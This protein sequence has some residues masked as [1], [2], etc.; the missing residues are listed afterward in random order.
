MRVRTAVLVPLMT[1]AISASDQP[2]VG[3]TGIFDARVLGGYALGIEDTPPHASIIGIAASARISDRWRLGVEILDANL[4]GPYE[5]ERRAWLV[6]PV[7][8]WVFLPEA[9]FRPYMVFGFGFTQWRTLEPNPLHYFDPTL[10]EFEWR[11]QNGVNLAGGLGL[12]FYLTKR[13]FVAPE[14]RI[15][16]LPLLRITA[17]VGYSF[18]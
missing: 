9:Q 12:R 16:L 13:L 17:S 1:L 14:I 5:Y 10:A 4:F 11:E 8:E 18:F 7:F 15:G 6:T 3:Q 2:L